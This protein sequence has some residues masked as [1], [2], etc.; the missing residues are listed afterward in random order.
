MKRDIKS[1][2]S[3]SLAAMD[4]PFSSLPV[5]TTLDVSPD[6]RRDDG[7]YDS[8]KVVDDSI[9]LMKGIPLDIFSWSE[10]MT[11]EVRPLPIH[12]EA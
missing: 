7:V 6:V 2:L 11:I 4:Q 12:T 5:G 9:L 8:I 1:I 10:G 3:V